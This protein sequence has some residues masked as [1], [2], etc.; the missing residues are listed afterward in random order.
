MQHTYVYLTRIAELSR[1]I[2]YMYSVHE[3]L[4]M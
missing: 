1:Y 2:V 4:E 3:L